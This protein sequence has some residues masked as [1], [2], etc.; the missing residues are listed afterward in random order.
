MFNQSMVF[1]AYMSLFNNA[2]L[3]HTIHVILTGFLFSSHLS[4]TYV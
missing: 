4:K 1:S 2:M 3:A